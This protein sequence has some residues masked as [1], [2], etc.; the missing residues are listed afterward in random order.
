M[1]LYK[2]STNFGNLPNPSIVS[3]VINPL[4]GDKITLEL[5]VEDKII[6]KAMFSG[7]ICGVAKV[8]AA[9]LTQVLEGMNID[10]AKK[11]DQNKVLELIGFELTTNRQKCA[12]LVLDA[13]SE[14]LS[15]LNK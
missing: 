9:A 11:I 12:T 10:D 14:C 4:C 15:G 2:N 3:Q 6:T 1:D 7:N 13:L 5:L 8:S